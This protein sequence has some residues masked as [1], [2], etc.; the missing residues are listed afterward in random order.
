MGE[1]VRTPLKLSLP[2]YSVLPSAGSNIADLSFHVFYTVTRGTGDLR[3]LLRLLCTLRR[4]IQYAVC[5]C[6]SGCAFAHMTFSDI[7]RPTRHRT[8]HG[9]RGAVDAQVLHGK[10]KG[11]RSHPA[12]EHILR[13]GS[14]GSWLFHYRITC[15]L[16]C[17]HLYAEYCRTLQLYLHKFNLNSGLVV[18][19]RLFYIILRFKSWGSASSQFSKTRRRATPSEC[20]A[21]G[22]VDP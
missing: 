7:T 14:G 12:D 15:L 19:S 11:S 21:N 3:R 9:C 4:C 10:A 6:C 18:V 2:Y 22:S 20:P 16:Y 5:F 17:I 1:V 13:P 8:R